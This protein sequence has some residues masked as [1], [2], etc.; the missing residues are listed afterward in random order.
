M[1]VKPDGQQWTVQE[2]I[3]EDPASGLTFQFE[4]IQGSTARYRLRVFGD[5]RFGNRE[6]LFDNEG[7]EAGAGT[8]VSGFCRPTWLCE[9]DP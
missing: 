6:I 2:Q 1:A 9:I 7:K 5:I 3:V 8:A 4:V